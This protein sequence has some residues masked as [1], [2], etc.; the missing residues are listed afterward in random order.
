MRDKKTGEP[1][2]RW[3]FTCR[4]RRLGTWP[5]GYCAEHEPHD[6]PT[7]ARQCYRR[8]LLDRRLRLAGRMSGQARP[9]EVCG[10]WTDRFAEVDHG[11]LWALCDE[12]R[13]REVVEERFDAPDR[14][15]SSW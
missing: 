10:E 14:I 2:G 5:V 7:E 13:T 12:H 6:S 9:C 15:V 4:N 1:T 3:H 11:S 8:W